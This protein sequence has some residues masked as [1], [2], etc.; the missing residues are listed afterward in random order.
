[1]DTNND[2]LIAQAAPPLF[3]LYCAD[4]RGN[5]KNTHYPHKME[6]RDEASLKEAVSRDYVCGEFRDAYRGN[7]NFIGSDCLAMDCDND[8]SD[9]PEEWK[10]PLDVAAVF[11]NVR[12][13]VQYSR[14]HN[15]QKGG[16]SPRPR[17]HIIF[18]IAYEQS[19]EQYRNIKIRLTELFPYFDTNA[20][21][22]AR[23]LFGTEDAQVEIHPGDMNLTDFLDRSALPVPV[24]PSSACP[25][26]QQTG[27]LG[28]II[29][30]G[31]RNSIMH[32]YAL[33]L[34]KRFGNEGREGYEQFLTRA[35][36]CRPPLTYQELDTIWGNAQS[37]YEKTIASSDG[38]VPPDEYDILAATYRPDDY[39][40]VGQAKALARIYR[41]Q[42]RWSSATSFLCFDKG[43]W[44]ES[45]SR[46][47]ALLHDL[48]EHQMKEAESEMRQLQ[49][50]ADDAVVAY[51]GDIP[52]NVKEHLQQRM[53]SAQK[54]LAFV[55]QRRNSNFISAA[56]REVHPMVEID[57]EQLDSNEF[58]LTTPNATY[59]LQKGMEGGRPHSPNDFITKITAVSPGQK[60]QEL[61]LSFLSQIFH[62][63]PELI[64]YRQMICGL[65][66]IGKVF[67]EAVII[68]YGDGG[69]GKSTFWNAIFMALGDYG[70]R[71][72]ADTLTVGCYR[73]TKPELA[74][75]RGKRLLIAA[76]SQE[77]ARL[78]ESLI[79]Q[80]CS[81]DDVFAEKKYKDPFKFKP[82]HTLVLYTNHLPRVSSSDTGIWRRLIVTP[83]TASI[84]PDQDIK[85]YGDYLFQN[86]GEYILA[87]V[88]EGARKVIEVR[89]KLVMPQCVQD[90][91]NEYKNQND[92]LGRFLSEKCELGE[93]FEVRSGELYQQYSLFCRSINES[94]SSTTDFYSSLERYG[95]K[96]LKRSNRR[97]IT[98]LRFL[99]QDSSSPVMS[100]ET[101]FTPPI[102]N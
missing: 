75:I 4:S 80:L 96:H 42:L 90:A 86:A 20:V 29:P 6:V 11:P 93:N 72:S 83:F 40:D 63:D 79:K 56:L 57:P 51:N 48:T 26:R 100:A 99:E 102:L 94:A 32:Q 88:I 1:M 24:A 45:E 66:T 61:W 78:N 92:T 3:T 71:I 44:M 59:D 65:T 74:E 15:K 62:N 60:G 52:D 10:T 43:Y 69:N 12:F 2:P 30:E 36:D 14:N 53:S 68:A 9:N 84:Q 89:F 85:N 70:G 50:E 97:F 64:D 33:R 77:G 17:F 49:K 23:F 81:T 101:A 16:F 34:L 35:Q 82:S 13:A 38:Y 25:Q 46:A 31:Q 73:N 54:Y 47:Q 41:N 18:L 28:K 5:A 98:G 22:T 21:D 39:S 37:F 76:E 87:W 67:V 91:V 55:T 7:G 95:L 19:P 27:D 58:L 8:H